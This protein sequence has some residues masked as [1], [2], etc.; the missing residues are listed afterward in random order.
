[1]PTGQSLLG[2]HGTLTLPELK[3][4]EEGQQLGSVEFEMAALA[5]EMGV[6]PTSKGDVAASVSGR[7]ELIP[8]RSSLTRDEA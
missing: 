3:L 4:G 5:A 6:V 1:M 8:S 7:T 2:P